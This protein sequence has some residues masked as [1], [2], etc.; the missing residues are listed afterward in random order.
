MAQTTPTIYL[1][2]DTYTVY[3]A[4]TDGYAVISN[5][6]QHR[7]RIKAEARYHQALASAANG[8]RERASATLLTNYGKVLADEH[9]DHEVQPEPEPEQGE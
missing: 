5:I 9:Y 2:L 1:V 8:T 6:T 4:E 7:D 3:D